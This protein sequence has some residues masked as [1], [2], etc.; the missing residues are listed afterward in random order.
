MM[1]ALVFGS[2]V[3]AGLASAAI[4]SAHAADVGYCEQYAR[5]A[6]VQVRAGLSV[7]SCRPSLAG[8]RWSADYH[9]HYDWCR[10]VS[11][12]DAQTE[13]SV[14]TDTIASCRR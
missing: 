2:L 12:N 1:K 14:R 3:A 7:P 8:N 10:N 5:A 6:L 4:P 9:V 13:R 11:R